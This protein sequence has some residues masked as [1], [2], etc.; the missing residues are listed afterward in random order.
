MRFR[1]D[2]ATTFVAAVKVL[3]VDW[4]SSSLQQSGSEVSM[5]NLVKLTLRKILGSVLVKR[6]ELE[7]L[8]YCIDSPEASESLSR[9]FLGKKKERMWTCWHEEAKKGCMIWSA[10]PISPFTH[11]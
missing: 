9:E 11:N 10:W 4:V 2:N 5:N 8:L 1:S 6:E 3:N 7:M